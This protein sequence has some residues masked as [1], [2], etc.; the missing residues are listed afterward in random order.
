MI[1]SNRSELKTYCLRKLGFPVI[2]INVDD[3]QLDDRIDEAVKR[4]QTFHYD[5]KEKWYTSHQITAGDIANTYIQMANDVIGVT[6]IFTLGSSQT[7]SSGTGGF[8]MF[9]INYQIR[10]N[11][12]Y[13]YTAGDYVYFELANEHLRMLEMLF[14]G[15]IPIRYNRYT[16]ILH[17]D[18][19]WKIRF[20]PG[21]FIIIELYRA[22]DNSSTFWGDDWLMKYTTSLFKEQWGSNLKKF[23]AVTLPGNMVLQGQQIY[24]EAIEEKAFLEKQLREEFE[25]PCEWFIG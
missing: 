4:F 21:E 12:L 25:D 6:R 19:A 14:T 2:Q 13:D 15:E 16:N 20:T 24:N 7:N 18:A 10:L 17:I 5:G 23:G 1:P 8:N 22:L 3:D 11:E 9:D